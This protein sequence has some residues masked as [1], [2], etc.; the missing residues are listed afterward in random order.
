MSPFSMIILNLQKQFSTLSDLCTSVLRHNLKIQIE[1]KQNKAINS[2]QEFET[3]LLSWK[4]STA[5]QGT[6]STNAL[7]SVLDSDPKIQFVPQSIR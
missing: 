7:S 2:N 3:V 5:G 6:I 1:M 4:Q